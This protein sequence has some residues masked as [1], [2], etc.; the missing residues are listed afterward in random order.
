MMSAVN[1]VFNSGGKEDMRIEMC[2][3]IFSSY[4]MSSLFHIL[5]PLMLQEISSC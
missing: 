2:W 4:P 3:M 5:S 1:S